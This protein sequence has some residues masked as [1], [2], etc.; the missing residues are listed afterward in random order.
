ML[1]ERG[2]IAEVVAERH[3]GVIDEEIERLDALD[4]CL[5]LL[6]VGHV[7]GQGRDVL[8]GVN[9]G[10]RVPAYARFAPLRRAS[11][12]RAC[13]MPRLAPVTRTVLS[14]IVITSS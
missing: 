14:E 3:A 1:L 4:C 2:N 10:R 9:Q 7:Q 13:P 11:S 8:I 5:D 12:T 6:C